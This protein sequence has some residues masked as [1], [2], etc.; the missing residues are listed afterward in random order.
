MKVFIL[1]LLLWNFYKC[2]LSRMIPH[3]VC[4]FSS[5]WKCFNVDFRFCFWQHEK[6]VVVINLEVVCVLFFSWITTL[7]IIQ[8]ERRKQ[9]VHLEATTTP[10]K[11]R[12]IFLW[13]LMIQKF[14]HSYR[15]E[16]VFPFFDY[17]NSS[18][19]SLMMLI[20]C[21]VWKLSFKDKH[22]NFLVFLSFFFEAQKK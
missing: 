2:E 13:N 7:N 3:I 19:F 12:I 18:H 16:S 21:I 1:S 20:L 9:N 6:N 5:K 14:S 4:R 17:L 8:I 15:F 10:H 22:D 11:A